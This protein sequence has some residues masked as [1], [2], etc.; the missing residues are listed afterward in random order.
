[1]AWVADF[2]SSD[3]YQTLHRRKPDAFA[4][5]FTLPT[6]HCFAHS[7]VYGSEGAGAQYLRLLEGLGPERT[8]VHFLSFDPAP[9][10]KAHSVWAPRPEKGFHRSDDAGRYHFAGLGPSL[11]RLKEQYPAVRSVRS[12]GHLSPLDWLHAATVLPG[13]DLFI[14]PDEEI[15]PGPFMNG[16]QVATLE[17]ALGT[18]GLHMR[19]SRTVVLPTRVQSPGALVPVPRPEDLAAE[20]LMPEVA[21]LLF[22]YSW[23]P[24]TQEPWRKLAATIG[25]VGRC[26][27]IRDKLIVSN[28]IHRWSDQLDEPSDLLVDFALYLMGAMDALV[29]AVR[30]TYA[31]PPARTH[32]RAILVG[33]VPHIESPG[34][35]DIDYFRDVL[36]ILRNTIHEEEF[37]RGSETGRTNLGDHPYIPSD[38]VDKFVLAAQKLGGLGRWCPAGVVDQDGRPN[39]K[40]IK[41]RPVPLAEDLLIRAITYIRRAA[42]ADPWK[43]FHDQQPRERS[44]YPYD[45]APELLPLLYGLGAIEALMKG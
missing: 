19:L 8:G 12:D 37:T 14:V 39:T 11:E 28:S 41:I 6:L 35:R 42:Q 17:D 27:A 1:M 44:T 16:I 23:D 26:L 15:Y 33:A 34:A 40:H 38:E 32:W 24:G 13:I 29:R 25:R 5:V 45:P 10:K 31:D 20:E 4:P 21:S 36:S 18:I 2:T 9:A 22:H 3:R 43:G 30:H 7:S